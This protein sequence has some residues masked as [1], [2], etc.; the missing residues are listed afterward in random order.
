MDDFKKSYSKLQVPLDP[1]GYTMSFTDPEDAG[2]AEFFE[3]YGFVVV[4][5][6]LSGEECNESM[7]SFG[8]EL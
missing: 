7:M 6:V 1:D 3:T 4:D 2:L 5:G 8:G